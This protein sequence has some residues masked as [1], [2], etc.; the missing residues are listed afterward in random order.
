MVEVGSVCTRMFK[1]L[2]MNSDQLQKILEQCWDRDISADDAMGMI[3]GQDFEGHTKK[4]P[5]NL[6]LKM[7]MHGT[8][9]LANEYYFGD[10][11][12]EEDLSKAVALYHQLAKQGNI[13]AME[14]LSDAYDCGNGVEM[15]QKEARRWLEKAEDALREKEKRKKHLTG[16]EK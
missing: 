2:Q 16:S 14:R 1:I 3:Y 10:R 4:L 12:T 11:S 7:T 8:L 9:L 15:D 5:L 6:N 13:Q